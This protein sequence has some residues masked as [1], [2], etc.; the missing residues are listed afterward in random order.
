[1]KQLGGREFPIVDALP[2]GHGGIY[3][4]NSGAA[5]ALLPE[6]VGKKFQRDEVLIQTVGDSLVLA[7]DFPRGTLYA[8]YTLLEEYLGVR[9][10]TSQAEYVPPVGELR[11]PELSNRYAPP[12][13]SRE[14]YYWDVMSHPVFAARMKNNGQFEEIPEEYGGHVAILG[15]CHTFWRLLPAEKYYGDHPEW[16]SLVGGKRIAGNA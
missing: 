3:V 4:G 8:V 13:F 7:G 16:F 9:W 15:W 12:F 6:L 2:A 10:W 14:A 1:M 5:R 11:L